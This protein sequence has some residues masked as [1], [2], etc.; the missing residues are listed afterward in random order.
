VRATLALALVALSM[1][2]CFGPDP[3]VTG[4]GKARPEVE[5][6]APAEASSGDVVDVRLAIANP[7]PGAFDSI[8]V[9]FSRLGDADLPPPLVD[10]A[11][12]RGP[13]PVASVDPKPNA[14]GQNGVVYTFDGLDEG[15]SMTITFEVT[16]P[17]V[18][19]IG[20]SVGNAV[21]VYD[22]AEPNRARGVRLEIEVPR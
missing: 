16:V 9:A 12:R 13:K 2:A 6:S 5:V 4:E 15:D 20:S 14:V 1:G 18:T 17:P 19:E 22:G 21:V 3:N 10:V 11:P 8:V 7:G